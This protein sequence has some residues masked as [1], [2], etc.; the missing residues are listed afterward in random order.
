MLEKVGYEQWSGRNLYR[1]LKEINFKTKN[2]KNLSLSNVYLI[3]KN[4]F[5]CGIFEYPR[6]SGNW[7]TGRHTPLITK[8]LFDKVQEQIREHIIRSDRKE[9]AFTKLI[10]CGLCGSGITADEKFKKLKDGGV[11]R[12][13]YYGCTKS[14][15]INCKCGYVREKEL[16]N[17]LLKIIDKISLDKIG[18]REKIEKE[19]E[20]YHKFRSGVLGVEKK[21][22]KESKEINIKNYAKYILKEGTIYEKRELLS[23]LKSKL[24]LKNKIVCL[25]K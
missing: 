3:L 22:N 24:V 19:I 20:R 14:K 1:W 11:N 7:Y 17:Q 9:F 18:M 2:G 13:V 16:L 12:Y 21:E 5:Y 10:K 15:D 8:E 23:C 25:E 6:N 4:P